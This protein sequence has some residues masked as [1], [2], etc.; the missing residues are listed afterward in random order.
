M[1][2]FGADHTLLNPL[3]QAVQ[4]GLGHLPGRLARGHHHNP[5]GKVRMGQGAGH[6]FIR[7]NGTDGRGHNGVGIRTKS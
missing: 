7:L 6:C 3:A 4:G 1:P 2:V 5:S